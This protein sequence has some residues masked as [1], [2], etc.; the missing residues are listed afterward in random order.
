MKL[1]FLPPLSRLLLHGYHHYIDKGAKIHTTNTQQ[2]IVI[3]REFAGLPSSIFF[4]KSRNQDI[5]RDGSRA[6]QLSK[7]T[8]DVDVC[9]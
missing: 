7:D 2:K 8:Q 4:S 1:K 9:S 6:C 5:V 3:K